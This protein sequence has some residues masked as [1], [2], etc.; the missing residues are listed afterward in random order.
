MSGGVDPSDGGWL[1]SGSL[2][3]GYTD[4][5]GQK[6]KTGQDL[7]AHD[8]SI[9]QTDRRICSQIVTV[10]LIYFAKPWSTRGDRDLS[11]SRLAMRH[12]ME[13]SRIQPEATPLPFI[14][15]IHSG[16]PG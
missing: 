10:L 14:P 11:S 4:G 1:S 7:L 13:E 5:E 9:Q 16:R 8:S 6:E 12:M 2:R 15:T 3:K